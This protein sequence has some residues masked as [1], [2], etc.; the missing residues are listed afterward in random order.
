MDAMTGAIR[1]KTPKI[2]IVEDDPSVR[3]SL[4]LLVQ[5]QGFETRTFASA[6]ALLAAS[7]VQAPDCLVVDYQLDE[8][9]DGIT[10]LPAL[11]ARGWSA[12]AILITGF[13]SSQVS[14]RASDCGFALVFE[15][16]LRERSLIEALKRLVPETSG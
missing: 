3:R 1:P 10:L 13:P 2:V 15:K 4:Q 9:V 7:E 16:P 5:G 6:E 11:R 8:G 12:P 14:Q